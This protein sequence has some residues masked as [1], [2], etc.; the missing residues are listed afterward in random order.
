MGK[1]GGSAEALRSAKWGEVG[2]GS[3]QIFMRSPIF[4][5]LC[6]F[7]MFM[8]KNDL[9]K[10]PQ[11]NFCSQSRYHYKKRLKKVPQ[12]KKFIGEVN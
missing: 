12:A 9:K 5:F 7:L 6:N 2:G 1:G 4:R 3:G 10:T 11:A 8:Q